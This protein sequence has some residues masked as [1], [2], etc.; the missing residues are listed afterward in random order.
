MIDPRLQGTSKVQSYQ[1][2][3]VNAQA[4]H[5]AQMAQ[6]RP[7]RV[8]YAAVL[9]SWW[10]NNAPRRDT[11]IAITCA[12]GQRSSLIASRLMTCGFTQLYNGT[13]G[14][15]PWTAAQLPVEKKS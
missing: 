10:R 13:G 11:P 1:Y 15:K 2:D 5:G 14:M 9:T 7:D 3:A 6:A 4:P 12:G 8:N